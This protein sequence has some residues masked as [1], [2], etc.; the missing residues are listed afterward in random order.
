MTRLTDK[1]LSLI[2]VLIA[3]VLF[4]LVSLAFG[5]TLISS[6]LFVASCVDKRQ[7]VCLAQQRLEELKAQG[8]DAVETLV[9][10]STDEDP[11]AGYPDYKRITQAVYVEDEDFSNQ[12][13]QATNTIMISAQVTPATGS[14]LTPFSVELYSIVVR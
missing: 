5:H 1:G 3:A 2:E 12:S 11:V 9:V 10:F 14:P 4:G 8:F 6:R 7:A 13:A